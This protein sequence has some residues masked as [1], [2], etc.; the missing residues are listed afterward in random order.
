MLLNGKTIIVTG[1]TTGIGAAIARECI[2]HG[3]NVMLH[4]RNQARAQA[5]ADTLGKQASY[6]IADL[7][8]AANMQQLVSQTVETFGAIHG[9]V[10]NAGMYPRNDIHSLQADEFNHILAVNLTSPLLLCQQVIKHLQ[11]QHIAGAIV[12]IGSINAYCGQDDLLGY[13]ISKGGLMTMTRNLADSLA[14]SG[15]RVNQ[16]NVGWTLTENEQ[17]TKHNEGL[18]EDWEQHVPKTFAP[19]G[20]ILRPEEIARHV[21]FWLSDYSAPANGVVYELEQYPVLG[22]NLINKMQVVNNDKA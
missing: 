16:L 12:N 13:S 18:P 8:D 6:C 19:R 14:S 21:A 7:S 9:L 4:G 3:A 10:N 20:H 17:Q 2:T 11:A 22:R 1:S 5:L 15:I